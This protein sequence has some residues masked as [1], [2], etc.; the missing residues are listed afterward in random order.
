[1][2]DPAH[3][4]GVFSSLTDENIEHILEYISDPRD[5]LACETSCSTF[6][7]V[8]S[9]DAVWRHCPG[10]DADM[11]DTYRDNACIN[12]VLNDINEEQKSSHNHLGDV[13]SPES[14][15]RMTNEVVESGRY[16]PGRHLFFQVRGDSLGCALNIIE[17][18]V[19]VRQK[20]RATS[21]EFLLWYKFYI[22][23]TI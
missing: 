5:L 18:H 14:V 16:V 2:A 11:V 23:P 21:I 4:V 17:A 10:A 7:N 13:L 3:N 22:Q 19:R 20:F 6:K 1:M 8:L 15:Q 12:C 9:S